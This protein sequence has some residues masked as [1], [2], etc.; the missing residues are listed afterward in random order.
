MT[1]VQ[2]NIKII[3]VPVSF[4]QTKIEVL[5]IMLHVYLY[6]LFL[7]LCLVNCLLVLFCF[8]FVFW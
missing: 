3:F 6:E 4:F 2:S 5:R 1:H 7:S 8:V